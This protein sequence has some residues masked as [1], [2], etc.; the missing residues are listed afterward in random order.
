MTLGNMR[1]NGTRTLRL[2]CGC[3]HVGTVDADR[4]PDTGPA[5]LP[6]MRLV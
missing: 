5:P 4:W 1:A 2:Q 6:R 3:G